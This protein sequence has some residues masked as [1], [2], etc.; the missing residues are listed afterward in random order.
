MAPLIIAYL[1]LAGPWARIAGGGRSRASSAFGHPGRSITA[2]AQGSSWHEA[3]V[4]GVAKFAAALWG[5]SGLASWR[6]DCDWAA[7]SR[8]RLWTV[9][10]PSPVMR[11]TFV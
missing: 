3:G 7:I 10:V 4:F 1:V 11:A 6:R 9:P 8:L 2:P 5:S